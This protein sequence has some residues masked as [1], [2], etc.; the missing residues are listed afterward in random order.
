[1]NRTFLPDDDHLIISFQELET[2]W[3]MM[4]VP[5]KLKHIDDTIAAVRRINQAHGPQKAVFNMVSATAWLTAD[6][7]DADIGIASDNG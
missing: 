6:D 4:A 1:M 2:A 3:R 5:D 7:C